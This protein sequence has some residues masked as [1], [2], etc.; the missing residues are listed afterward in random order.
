MRPLMWHSWVA[1]WCRWVGTTCWNRRRWQSRCWRVPAPSM[2]RKQPGCW[3][4]AARCGVSAMARAWR[5]R[6]RKYWMIRRWRVPWGHAQRPRLPPIAA[7]R[8]ERFR[9][10][11]GWRSWGSVARRRLHRH[12]QPAV[13]FLDHAAIEVTRRQAQRDD[14]VQV[15]ILRRRVV[16]LRLDQQAAR[17]EHVDRGTRTHFVARLV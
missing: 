14:V 8:R 1:R 4:S 2:R 15:G 3:R 17:I 7:P 10:L 16:R 5:L 12:R 6:C 9:L 11:L 13:D